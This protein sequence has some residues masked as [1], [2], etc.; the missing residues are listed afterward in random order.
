MNKFITFSFD[1][2]VLQDLRIIKILNKYNLRATF[3]LN[4][5]RF[6]IS[7]PLLYNGVII[8]R[9]VILPDMIHEYDGHEIAVHTLNH[10]KLSN[11]SEEDIAR[12]INVDAENLEKLVGYKVEGMAYP[13]SE[14][15]DRVL[16]VIKTKT[17]IKYATTIVPL[18]NLKPCSDL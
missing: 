5:G 15:D 7:F 9:K 4:S 8:E 2:G 17:F 18:L 13:W 6:G 10:A 1:D 11:L 3:N 12:E 16:N 14:F